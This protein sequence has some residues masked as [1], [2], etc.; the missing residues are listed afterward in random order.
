MNVFLKIVN[1]VFFN[2]LGGSVT[3]WL[4]SFMNSWSYALAI[5]TGIS[6]LIINIMK[7]RGMYIDQKIKLKRMNKRKK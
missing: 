5:C 2:L 7:I 1:L 6:L 4:I 3:L